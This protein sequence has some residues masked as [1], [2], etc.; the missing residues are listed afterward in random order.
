MSRVAPPIGK[1]ST[2]GIPEVLEKGTKTTNPQ[3]ATKMSTDQAGEAN[4]LLATT[5]QRSVENRHPEE[6]ALP[7]GEGVWGRGG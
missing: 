1:P 2:D 4:E 3:Q 5:R 6:F 7:P